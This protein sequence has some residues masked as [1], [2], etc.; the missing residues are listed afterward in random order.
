[1]DIEPRPHL[2]V[3]PFAAALCA[4]V[5]IVLWA[6]FV[7]DIRAWIAAAFPGRFT[8]IVAA[9]VGVA[10][11]GAT[12][13]ALLRIRDRRPYRY[14]AIT[15]ALIF[16]TAYAV[17]V[18]TG[19]PSVDAVERFHFVEYGAVTLLFFRAWRPLGDL[20][21]LLLP[22]LAGLIVGAADELIQWF[23]PFRV[24]ELHDIFLNGAAIASGLLF[25]LGFDP[26]LRFLPTIHRASAGRLA[27]MSAAFVFAI[28]AFVATVHLGHENR[29]DEAGTF[30]SRFTVAQLL[31]LSRDRAARWQGQMVTAPRRLSREDQYPSE[32]MWHVRRR[33]ERAEQ[34]NLAA[35]WGENQ[36]LERF[37]LPAIRTPTYLSGAGAEWTA[38]Q[39]AH[40]APH[41][42]TAPGAYVSDAE[43]H[44]IYLW[45]QTTVWT[46]AAALI[47]GLLIA[48]RRIAVSL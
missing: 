21:V 12:V 9:I 40:F 16:G 3:A 45:S 32:A 27:R 38:E 35:A 26:P 33:N 19:D 25:S 31:E 13:G 14:A 28:A 37:F 43:V 17:A 11:A 46:L 20:S 18:R 44:P 22:A 10:I 4:A 42:A 39:R 5:T 2:R 34:M 23:V 48:G 29:D 30:R 15:G 1:L 6:P 47:A 36:I 41:G 8:V 24:G 7:G